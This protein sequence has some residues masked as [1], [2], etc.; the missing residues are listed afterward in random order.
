MNESIAQRSAALF[1]SGFYCAE[2]VLLAVA[3]ARN[4]G[5]KLIPQ[6]ATGFCSGVAPLLRDVWCR[7]WGNSRHWAGDGAYVGR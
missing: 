6:I 7:I 5:C 3:E 2:S 1:D 4:V